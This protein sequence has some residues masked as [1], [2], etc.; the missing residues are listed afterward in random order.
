VRYFTKNDEWIDV[1]G[2]EGLLGITENQ[3]QQLGE[4]SFVELP[5]VGKEVA[6]GDALLT[7]ESVKA[8]I[9]FYAPMSGEILAVNNALEENPQLLGEKPE[10]IWIALIK[11]A[12]PGEVKTLMDQGAYEKY[13]NQD[14]SE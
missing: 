7:I 4:V 12:D 5:K 10:E 6:Q 14:S 11:L 2:N 13:Q 3:A 1:D 9:D 8:A